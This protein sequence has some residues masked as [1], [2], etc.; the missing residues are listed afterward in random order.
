MRRNKF[1][2]PVLSLLMTTSVFAGCASSGGENDS[3]SIVLNA[4]TVSF[5]N[6]CAATDPAPESI[7]VTP[8]SAYGELP[9]VT[10]ENEGYSFA[11]W[12]TRADGTGLFVTADTIVR[13]SYGDHTLYAVW[14]GN[15][16]KV[17]FDLGGGNVNGATTIY[18]KDVTYGEMYGNV[19]IPANPQKNLSVFK[20]WYL[21]PEG[22]GEKITSATKVRNA[23]DHT[24]YAV[25]KDIKL[26]YDFSDDTGLEDVYSLN[27]ALTFERVE[28]EDGNYLEISNT[29]DNPSGSLVFTSELTAGTTIELD[30]EFVGELPSEDVKAGFF[31]YGA[32]MDGSSINSGSLG[33]PSAD[34][35]S[36]E[37]QSWY[38]GQGARSATPWEAAVWNDGHLHFT[39]NVL[40][41]CYGL[42][43]LFEFGKRTVE[44]ETENDPDYDTDSSLWVN[45]KWRIHSIKI[46]YAQPKEELPIG[47]EVKVNFDLNYDEAGEAPESITVLTG[48]YYNNLP[49]LEERVGFEFAGWNTAKDGSGYSVFSGDSVVAYEEEITLYAIWRGITHTITYDL[50]G[51]TLDGADEISSVSVT[52]GERYGANVDYAPVK[53]G[54]IFTGWYFNADGTGKAIAN[55]DTV[56]LQEDVTVYA[57]YREAR[58]EFDFTTEDQREYFGLAVNTQYDIVTDGNDS[59]LKVTGLANSAENILVLRNP[60][61]A[62]KTV[63]VDIEYVANDLT[64]A[65][66]ENQ[67]T[68]LVYGANADGSENGAAAVIGNAPWDGGWSCQKT[69]LSYA[70]AADCYGVRLQFKFNGDEGA[71]F[72]I[73]GIR[74]V[75]IETLTYTVNYEL[76]GGT[77][78][79]AASVDGN[80]VTY[81]NAYGDLPAD[82]VK[83]NYTFKGW[84]LNADGTGEAVTA[85]TVVNTLSDHTLYAIYERVAAEI[86][87]PL[88][89]DFSDA[90]Q[91]GDF[92]ALDNGKLEIAEDGNGN[93]LK[94]TPA[95]NTV[96]SDNT[97][98]SVFW[99]NCPLK[100]GMTVVMSFELVGD[101][102]V[103][104][105]VWTYGAGENGAELFDGQWTTAWDAPDRWNNGCFIA[106]TEITED[107]YGVRILVRYAK[108]ADAYWKIKSVVVVD[109]AYPSYTVTYNADGTES[110]ATVTYA[111]AYGELPDA[112]EKTGYTFKGWNTRADGTGEAVTAETLVSTAGDH[113]LYAIYEENVV[114]EEPTT[115]TE[116]T[117]SD[118][119]ELEDFGYTEGASY[120]WV[121][122]TDGNYLKVTGVMDS[123][124]NIIVLDNA[125]A[126]G[127]TVEV[128]IEYISTDVTFVNG[129]NQVTFLMYGANADNSENGSPAVMGSATWDGA[130]DCQKTTVSLAVSADAVGV[131]L[132]FRFNAVEGSYFKITGI[133]IVES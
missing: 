29:T 100:A 51:G 86:E 14:S 124:A 88:V 83:E 73:T 82:P 106:T 125:L 89:Y 71:Y 11:G 108:N 19:V 27:D 4:V 123:A 18:A 25:Y 36:P 62:G 50:C 44:P 13:P 43:M 120:E 99:F 111:S 96:S 54:K 67:I 85:E 72:K 63:E 101:I 1:M 32:N 47:T 45:N 76:N 129:V 2:I 34:G 133:R 55:T 38:W 60:V 23:G 127:K 79:G 112:P 87:Y 70:V 109:G 122:D 121:E 66:G 69:T 75:D 21:N 56:D 97:P 119:A 68:F 52:N 5:D 30:L 61:S 22:T 59:Y 42:N 93:Y 39:V 130:W 128:D 53:D 35:A 24:L 92:V 17:S 40:E 77:V 98:Q 115:R 102:N 64:F 116:Y 74:I 7:T 9:V 26:D 118:E 110:T 16:Y 3:T 94:L 57:V 132:Q 46:N 8:N 84:Y 107:C 65:N 104:H 131:R 105:G 103:G 114:P 6:N 37:L 58:S 10:A 80:S 113:T 20:G 126:A 28:S 90:S 117:F 31:F 48:D 78:N 41:R 91:I 12:N 49:S 15:P 33:N 81:G 95:D